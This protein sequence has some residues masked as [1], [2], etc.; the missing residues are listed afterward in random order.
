[1]Q[2]NDHIAHVT[3]DKDF[4]LYIWARNV[5]TFHSGIQ[6]TTL[7]S[8]FRGVGSTGRDDGLV[9]DVPPQTGMGLGFIGARVGPLLQL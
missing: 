7:P 3:S 8:Q 4:V 2:D 1:L 6:I 9:L 5:E